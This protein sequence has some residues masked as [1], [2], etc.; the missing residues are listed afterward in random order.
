MP[1]EACFVSVKNPEK[2]A[3]SEKNIF[4]G[5]FRLPA[6]TVF[7]GRGLI[8][9]M[10]DHLNQVQDKTLFHPSP[11]TTKERE[12]YSKTAKEQKR[13]PEDGQFAFWRLC[14]EA[15]DKDIAIKWVNHETREQISNKGPKGALLCIIYRRAKHS[16]NPKGRQFPIEIIKY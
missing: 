13:T 4:N 9:Q 6:N 15:A 8:R 5:L 12:E 3:D 14:K 16:S 10:L 2:L 1:Y 11:Q 7:S